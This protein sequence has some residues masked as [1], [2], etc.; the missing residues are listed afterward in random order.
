[1]R[2]TEEMNVLLLLLYF[3]LSKLMIMAG[4][5][6]AIENEHHFGADEHNC[7]LWMIEIEIFISI[8]F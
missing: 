4:R 8:L 1:M 7:N 3:P 2:E 6:R 5:D